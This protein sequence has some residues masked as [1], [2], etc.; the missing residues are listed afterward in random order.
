MQ[1]LNTI[2]QS[3]DKITSVPGLW[4][5][6]LT[7]Y[8]NDDRPGKN[9]QLTSLEQ[10]WYGHEEN[11]D[12]PASS[13]HPESVNVPHFKLMRDRVFN[14]VL[15]RTGIDV[16]DFDNIIHA[17]TSPGKDKDGNIIEHGNEKNI[18]RNV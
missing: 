17:T 18:V 16:R 13:E 14:S 1:N 6:S 8:Y 2:N 7:C 4:I 15:A 5:G 10:M 11:V 3:K 9:I 12:H